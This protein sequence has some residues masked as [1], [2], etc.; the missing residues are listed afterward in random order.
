M[1]H[2][3][4]QFLSLDANKKPTIRKGVN[5]QSYIPPVLPGGKPPAS[6]SSQL[7]KVHVAMDV[8]I[9]STLDK[10]SKTLPDMGPFNSIAQEIATEYFE[11]QTNAMKVES[12]PVTR[13]SNY[14]DGLE[15]SLDKIVKHENVD[16]AGN[17]ASANFSLDSLRAL[18]SR[19]EVWNE[20]SIKAT[21][22][23]GQVLSSEVDELLEEARVINQRVELPVEVLAKLRILQ[24]AGEAFSNKVRS[25]LTLKGKEKVPLRVLTDLMK[26]AEALPVETE[27]VRFFRNQRGRIQ[28]ICHSAQ[29]ASKDKS[30]D[31]SKDVTIEAAEVRAVLPD[32]DFLREQVSKGEWV[33]KAV[34]KTDKK[35]VLPLQTIE[36]LFDDPSAALIKPEEC[37]IMRV[38]KQAMD[39]AHEWQAKANQIITSGLSVNPTDG[40]GK[41]RMPS[42]EELQTLQEEHAKLNKIC[43]QALSSQ[44][45][46]II[47]RAKGWIKK[48]ER[49]LSGTWSLSDAK[50]LLD[51][52]HLISHQVDLNPEI[53]RLVMEVTKAEEWCGQ[54]RKFISG[55][56]LTDI[57]Q[58]EPL[59]N[60]SFKAQPIVETAVGITGDPAY[61]DRLSLKGKE[62]QALKNYENSLSD[63]TATLSSVRVHIVPLLESGR[64]PTQAELETLKTSL[65]IVRDTN[66]EEDVNQLHDGATKW[67]DRADSVI[68]VPFPRP[69][70]VLRS[71]A[72]L[73]HDLGSSPMRYHHWREIVQI[74]SEE[75]W[76]HGLRYIALPLPE[77]RHEHLLTSCP[78]PDTDM[79]DDTDVPANLV[80]AQAL[81][82]QIKSI[83][84]ERQEDW[85]R[86][87]IGL[88][89]RD[90]AVT[91]VGSEVSLLRKLKAVHNVYVRTCEDLLTPRRV[92][93]HTRAE[94]EE[95]MQFLTTS[96]ML[97]MPSLVNKVQLA[98]NRNTAF[99]NAS[100]NLKH[101]LDADFTAVKSGQ[102]S[103][104]KDLFHD[105]LSLLE[106]V[107]FSELKVEHFDSCFTPIV[108]KLLQYQANVRSLFKWDHD[109]LVTVIGFRPSLDELTSLWS[110]IT[111]EA[112]SAHQLSELFVRD[113][114][115]LASAHRALAEA[116]EW[117]SGLS[118]ISA[119]LRGQASATKV[120][121]ADLKRHVG[122]WT[123]LAV[124]V[125]YADIITNAEMHEIE[126]WSKQVI[127]SVNNK[128]KQ[129]KRASLEEALALVHSAPAPLCVHSLDFEILSS[130]VT[131][132]DKLRT[133]S[134][135]QIFQSAAERIKLT[136]PSSNQS[137]TPSVID[138]DPIGIELTRLLRE[139]RK[140]PIRIG[141]ENLI[142]AEL[143][144][145]SINRNL[146]KI[147]TRSHVVPL[148][149]VEP[150][151]E[152]IQE[153]LP[154]GT[155]EE[156]ESSESV[157][158]P[159]VSFLA[160]PVLVAAVREKVTLSRKWK[161]VAAQ[162]VAQL[163]IHHQLSALTPA[164]PG[165]GQ[166]TR[167]ASAV[168]TTA[169]SGNTPQGDQ[170]IALSNLEA[171]VSASLNA[172]QTVPGEK[173]LDILLRNLDREVPLKESG[174]ISLEIPPLEAGHAHPEYANPLPLY[175]LPS[176][177]P[178]STNAIPAP[179]AVAPQ[180]PEAKRSRKAGGSASRSS[181]GNAEA[182]Q[183]APAVPEN[184]LLLRGLSPMHQLLYQVPWTRPGLGYLSPLNELMMN[185]PREFSVSEKKKFAE[186]LSKPSPTLASA[187]TALLDHK[188]A[189][190]F[191]TPEYSRIRNMSAASLK[192]F[193]NCI[194]KFPY[195]Q[196]KPNAQESADIAVEMWER[197]VQ[198]STAHTSGSPLA[199]PA[200]DPTQTKPQEGDET[201]LVGF[202]LQLDALAFQIPTK[203]RILMLM[204][205]MY[206]WRVKSQC[207][208]HHMHRDSRPRPWAGDSRALAYWSTL[209]PPM[210]IFSGVAV[211]ASP[212]MGDALCLHVIPNQPPQDYILCP[213]HMCFYYVIESCRHF[214]RVM[215]DMCELCYGVTTTDQEEAFWI[216][217]D[218][219]D[220]WF[221]GPC[222]GLTHPVGAFTCPTCI[223]A[224]ASASVERKRSAMSLLNS[225]PP[226]RH[227]PVSPEQRKQ[228]AE[229][230][231]SEAKLHAIVVSMNPTELGI[232][233]RLTSHG[234]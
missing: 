6:R 145:R 158:L 13:S 191:Q 167:K 110:N 39:E 150:F 138:N 52:G 1:S 173:S 112:E 210:D 215:S 157:V 224:S 108:G 100:L 62:L 165:G 104:E 49:T 77:A 66:L 43:V 76:A 139:S 90:G 183:A 220:K 212:P 126:E 113:V 21:L 177:I 171:A 151:V 142:E 24:K 149:I 58:L 44:I 94:A 204:L 218:S 166:V 55:L 234:M 88:Q 180:E 195:L 121:V 179:A 9:G 29:K 163:P 222:A 80:R 37:E 106:T 79:D 217:C 181:R 83:L 201:E 20:R 182:G 56:S 137:E 162:L 65:G 17:A 170:A 28:T 48:Q 211:P 216:S 64:L 144:V 3:S 198:P 135:E 45:E 231:L 31:K 114:A 78:F 59:V 197:F 14:W 89:A 36:Q 53:G 205:D 186:R 133:L 11:S 34:S 33:Q 68:A 178:P 57:D 91:L 230:L 228:D 109:E 141:T 117:R 92:P 159:G 2:S 86:E 193:R 225:L 51:E 40:K 227:N 223:V 132:A 67:S 99:E 22:G 232:F 148:E 168:V 27:E 87:V 207:V 213:M 155:E 42:I 134:S 18:L 32:L 128:A 116:T 97:E 214:I 70:G 50:N 75:V 192:V 147:L 153:E 194:S 12:D 8:K 19:L 233:R 82:A 105:L 189:G 26:E 102:P 154:I 72:T 146:I 131:I 96:V 143:R 203:Y 184:P 156:S 74:A 115:Y 152:S 199:T 69:A 190:L 196:P 229:A 185:K 127:V 5:Y 172:P 129:R 61:I 60:T 187:L 30:L 38:L 54:A 124:Q 118:E 140:S 15:E 176:L 160:T 73:I 7:R 84:T 23:T 111:S 63:L 221:H 120:S 16:D 85:M 174:E 25:K 208:C 209:P 169:S 41:K 47:R 188:R 202:L 98:L 46:G 161:H 130:Q 164:G 136:V 123:S 93:M 122:H 206:D 103:P 226:R 4:N 95:F 219:C 125:P 107:E 10:L 200:D 175:Q 119:T 71:L 35:G 101:R 81:E